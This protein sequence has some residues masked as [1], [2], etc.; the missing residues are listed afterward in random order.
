[1]SIW[2][3]AFKGTDNESYKSKGNYMK[4]LKDDYERLLAHREL[5]IKRERPDY[6]ITAID[7][8]LNELIL[9]MDAYVRTGNCL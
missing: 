1:M 5:S 4:N 9:K 3:K 6:E 2:G 7:N 8:R